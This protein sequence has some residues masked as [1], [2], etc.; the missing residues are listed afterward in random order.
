MATTISGGALTL[1]ANLANFGSEARTAT[2]LFSSNGDQRILQTFALPPGS[3][4]PTRSTELPANVDGSLVV[5][6]DGPPGE[7]LSNIQA[8]PV[9]GTS[10]DSVPLP[11]KDGKQIPNGGQHP[12]RID[13]GLRSTLM[14][15]NPDPQKPNSV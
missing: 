12:W 9:S 8:V 4:S 7:I 11:W 13:G 5:Q 1:K 15:Y 10:L 6:A 2:V 3:V 14:L